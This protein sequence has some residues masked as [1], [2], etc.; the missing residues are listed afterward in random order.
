MQQFRFEPVVD[1]PDCGL[2][3]AGWDA[4][5]GAVVFN[6]APGPIDDVITAVG[7]YRSHSMLSH[8]PGGPVTHSTMRQPDR[9]PWPLV[10]GQPLVPDQ[11]QRGY[12]GVATVNQGAI[13][14]FLR[15]ST[16]LA[17]QRGDPA[18]AAQVANDIYWS[19][20]TT[21]GASRVDSAQPLDFP[22]RRHDSAWMPYSLFQYRN[23]E[24]SNRNPAFSANNGMVCSTFLA[25]AHRATG[26]WQ[27][28]PYTYPHGLVS[29]VADRLWNSVNDSCRT[30]LGPWAVLLTGV[31][32]GAD[33]CAN[34]A[35]QV[36]NCMAAN[37]CNDSNP[38]IWQGVRDDPFAVAATISPDRIG[39][40]GPHPWGL[41]TW[42]VDYNH[43]VFWNQS[44]N[45]Y[46]CW[47]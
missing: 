30:G 27:V 45:S 6:K 25:Y 36:A 24:G 31:C 13:F 37:V 15:G 40:W 14:E 7:E 46:G 4:P 12:P 11:L 26:L 20:N 2:V 41:T 44:G 1:G 39:G 17:Y 33:V 35:S 47:N 8:W 5:T 19:W 28:D 29:A 43:Q 21:F 10:C 22:L 3:A 16:F 32:V 9:N 34:S 42:S 18:R 23:I 38:A